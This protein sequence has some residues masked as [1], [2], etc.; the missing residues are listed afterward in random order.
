MR[1]TGASADDMLRSL[2]YLLPC[3]R[4]ST[5]YLGKAQ[6]SQSFYNWRRRRKGW[7][8]VPAPYGGNE[9]VNGFRLKPSKPVSSK[10]VSGRHRGWNFEMF[11]N[12]EARVEVGLRDA[13][14]FFMFTPSS[15]SVH[16]CVHH[17]LK[18]FHRCKHL[19]AASKTPVVEKCLRARSRHVSTDG[20]K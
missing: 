5:V 18:P 15:L 20:R 19:H 11:F 16:C 10:L 6:H 13:L 7:P 3:V 17:A 14:P 1:Q 8:Q 4:C 9:R 2:A 12:R